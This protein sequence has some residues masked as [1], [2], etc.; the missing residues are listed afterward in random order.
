MIPEKICTD[1]VVVKEMGSSI[2]TACKHCK[3][4]LCIYM[5]VFIIFLHCCHPM[6]IRLWSSQ[7]RMYYRLISTKWG[8][9][10]WRRKRRS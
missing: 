6:S 5:Q 1:A 4:V 2:E 9:S 10:R 8:E 3:L 7:V